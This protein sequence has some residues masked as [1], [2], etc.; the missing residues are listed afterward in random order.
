MR[1]SHTD[2]VCSLCSGPVLP[3]WKLC[4]CS[5]IINISDQL[6]INTNVM[7][8][9]AHKKVRWTSQVKASVKQKQQKKS[10]FY[11]PC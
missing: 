6:S 1:N 4:K 10:L 2:T 3:L 7:Y 8:I 11:S 5:I 9:H